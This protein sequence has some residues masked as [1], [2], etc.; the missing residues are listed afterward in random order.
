MVAIILLSVQTKTKRRVRRDANDDVE[1]RHEQL[2]SQAEI[3]TRRT[4]VA[5]TLVIALAVVALGTG[6]AQAVDCM[7]RFPEGRFG[8]APSHPAIAKLALEGFSTLYVV[9]QPITLSRAE[10][11]QYVYTGDVFRMI[12]THAV[13]ALLAGCSGDFDG[14]GRADV[15]LLMNRHRDGVVVP[16]VF[17][18]RGAQYRATEIENIIDP[19]GFA[20]DKSVWP[21]PFCT[22]K[23]ANGL[24]KSR[25]EGKS[26]KV[27]GDLFTIGWKSYF[28]N[29]TL[30]RFDGIFTSD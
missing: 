5:W 24:F 3:I 20:Q 21:G 17:Q 6:V 8:I 16:F 12:K 2:A 10:E 26:I 13:G 9:K 22:P 4:T 18:S 7:D 19:Q 30:Q 1:S 23:P 28:W 11:C 14:D 15:A 25:V 29:P 27:V